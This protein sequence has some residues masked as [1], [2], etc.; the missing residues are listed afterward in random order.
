MSI[1]RW[2]RLRASQGSATVAILT[3]SGLLTSAV[4]GVN[5]MERVLVTLVACFGG[6]G[7]SHVNDAGFWVVTRY[8]RLSV[9]DGLKTWTVLTTII[10]YRAERLCADLAGLG[11]G[12]TPRS[13]RFSPGQQGR[14]GC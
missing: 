1:A 11:A 6:L 2:R 14:K 9:A 10:G 12:V 7:L 4:S 13:L 3:T 5:D 8:L